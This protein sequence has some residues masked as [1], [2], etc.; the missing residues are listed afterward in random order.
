MKKTFIA[1]VAVCAAMFALPGVASAGT[2][3][4]GPL[5]LTFTA[6]GGTS[7]L[8]TLNAD[9]TVASRVHCTSNSASGAYETTTTGTATITFKG[10]TTS[11]GGGG[12][13][14]TTNGQ[15]SGTIVT[16]ALTFHNVMIHSNVPGI[17]MTPGPGGVFA[18]FVCGFIIPVTVEGN[19]VIGTITT[20]CGTETSSTELKFGATATN[21]QQHTQITTTGTVYDLKKGTATATQI[22]TS[23]LT[24][25]KKSKVECT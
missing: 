16:T 24:L 18:H 17:L 11:E 9:H 23:K 6:S 2:W 4:T 22:S 5:P 19:G 15:A 25:S 21:T 1:L 3:H 13:A 7:E 10:C 8:L 12:V 14:C 20:A